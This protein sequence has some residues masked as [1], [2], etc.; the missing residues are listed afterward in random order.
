MGKTIP[1]ARTAVAGVDHFLCTE[2]VEA[3]ASSAGLADAARP[4]L[5]APGQDSTKISLSTALIPGAVSAACRT[6]CCPSSTEATLDVRDSLR[7][8]PRRRCS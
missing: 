6:V 8:D 1:R 3:D 7:I 2:G 5:D 4:G